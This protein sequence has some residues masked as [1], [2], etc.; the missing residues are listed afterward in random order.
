MEPVPS[1]CPA[2]VRPGARRG[3]RPFAWLP[4]RLTDRIDPPANPGSR[5]TVQHPPS[6][7]RVVRRLEGLRHAIGAI[8]D[9]DGWP[10]ADVLA[11]LPGQRMHRVLGDFRSTVLVQ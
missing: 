5:R 2:R 4:D 7:L 11:I 8:Q 9:P 10:V 3:H 1:P 6:A